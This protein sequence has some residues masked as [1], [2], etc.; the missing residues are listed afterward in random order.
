MPMHRR[1]VLIEWGHC[2]P[3]GIVYYPRYLEKFDGATTAFIQEVTGQSK[4]QLRARFGIVGWPIVDSQARFFLPSRYGDRLRI[5][6]EATEIRLGRFTMRHRAYKGE[7]LAIE[8][9]ETRILAS[10]EG[11]TGIKPVPLP[12]GFAV[13]LKGEES[14][15]GG[16]GL[17]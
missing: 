17:G 14:G 16:P 3:A 7:N 5:D 15:E 6:T 12:A 10:A 13:R 9:F 8:A 11:A 1:E 4:H 2:D